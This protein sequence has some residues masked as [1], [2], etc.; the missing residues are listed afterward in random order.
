MY[1]ALSTLTFYGAFYV[2][3]M[4]LVLTSLVAVLLYVVH[5]N[6]SS[7]LQKALKYNIFNELVKGKVIFD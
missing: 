6:G 5:I 7:D 3:I 4:V 2:G 1:H